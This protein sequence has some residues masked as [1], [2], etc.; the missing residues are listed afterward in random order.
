[1][2]L[3][4]ERLEKIVRACLK[5]AEDDKLTPSKRLWWRMQARRGRILANRAC[6][7]ERQKKSE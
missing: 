7:L 1:M 5:A 2:S 3:N 4:S 6:E